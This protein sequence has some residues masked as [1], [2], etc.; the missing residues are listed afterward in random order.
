MTE[1]VGRQNAKV[2]T[3]LNEAAELDIRRQVQ[4]R[5]QTDGIN[6]LLSR[7]FGIWNIV[8]QP[9]RKNESPLEYRNRYEDIRDLATESVEP[10]Q[11][12]FSTGDGT[13][14]KV[15]GARIIKGD[16]LLIQLV[17]DDAPSDGD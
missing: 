17:P 13:L 9:M 6:R 15:D 7:L 8:R 4:I 1:S 5:N 16:R 10:S 3:L 2:Y 14:F 11:A 12:V